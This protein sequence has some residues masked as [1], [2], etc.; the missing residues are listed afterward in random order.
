[1]AS[2]RRFL[3][4][5]LNAVRPDR[6]EAGL[7]RE[8]ASHLALLEDEYRRR[9]M[10]DDDAQRAARRVLGGVDRTKELHRAARS[11]TWLD[12]LRR[13]LRYAVRTLA[14]SPIFTLVAIVS[15]TL[16]IGANTAMFQL[17]NA[18]LLRPLP[19]E[20]PHELV[21]V[22]LPER[23]L[24]VVRGNFPRYPALTYPMWERV[25][26]RQQA[27]AT[28]FAW[29]DDWFNLAPV[30]EVRRVP[31]VWV[32]GDYFPVLGLAPAAGRL[33]NRRRR[34]ARVRA[35]RRRGEPRLLAARAERRSARDRPAR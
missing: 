22:N 11:F 3:R 2:I 28:M 32:T 19:V 34:S 29:A 18:L 4:R 17:L 24:Q 13:D 5:L 25:R 26:E 35:A 6:A 27:F 12:D 23:D 8:I 14:R 10:S 15:L 9:G 20:R 30:G 31:G 1:M 33:F 21:E 7:E 16:G